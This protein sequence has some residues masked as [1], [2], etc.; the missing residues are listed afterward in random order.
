MANKERVFK[1]SRKTKETEIDL[2]LNID[3]GDYSISTGVGFLDHMLELFAKHGD[4]GIN[5]QAKGDIHIDYHHITED[6][7][8]ALGKAFKEASG[9][10]KGINRYG[11]MLL[12]MDETLIESAVD[13]SGRVYFNWAVDYSS[14]KVGEFDIELIEE[15]WRAFTN[16]AAIN[17]HIIKRYGSN[18]HHISEGI[19]KS[20]AKSLK[21]ALTITSDS[22]MSTKGV[23]E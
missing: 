16:N 4:F 12:P 5:L 9:D 20:V 22:L 23:L 17:L 10:K 1:F 15:F 6:I 14:N 3:G 8:I 19:F 21:S 7:G 11:F 2:T 18:T 13:F